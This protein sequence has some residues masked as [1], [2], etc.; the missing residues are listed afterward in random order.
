VFRGAF[1]LPG[2]AE[3]AALKL[4]LRS[5][6]DTQSV[7]VNGH[8]LA[9]N[10]KVD[11]VGYEYPLDRSLL[12][13][14]RNVVT[15]YVTRFSGSNKAMQAFSWDG[16]G[17][18]AVQ[19]AMPAPQWKRSVFNGLAQVIVQSKR[20]AGEIRLTATSSG[21][22]PAVANIASQAMPRVK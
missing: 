1:Y 9:R 16:P 6:G 19:V 14:G 2:E 15:L 5:V 10:L 21:L 7:Y 22:S 13:A 3:R 17:P 20:E 8:A 11:A 18:A 12:H 4:V